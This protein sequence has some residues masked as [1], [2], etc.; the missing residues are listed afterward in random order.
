[1]PTAD[2]EVS[3]SLS[4]LPI[5]KTGNITLTVLAY[6][7]DIAYGR[8]Q[9]FTYDTSL[10]N[11]QYYLTSMFNR[12]TNTSFSIT[13]SA[14][15]MI[16]LSSPF[17]TASDLPSDY[18]GASCKQDY[19]IFMPIGSELKKCGTTTSLPEERMTTDDFATRFYTSP[20]NVVDSC[21]DISRIT[22]YDDITDLAGRAIKV[23]PFG[24]T[25]ISLINKHQSG[26]LTYEGQ[27][28][29]YRQ[30]S[31]VQADGITAFGH[32]IHYLPATNEWISGSTQFF[33]LAKNCYLEFYIKADKIDLNYVKIDQTPLTNLTYTTKDI[34]LF[35]NNIKQFTTPIT[36]YGVHTFANDAGISVSY[37]V[38]K[39]VNGPYNAAGYLT[40]FNKVQN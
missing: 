24:S 38:C 9:I 5:S 16:T 14:P 26:F 34:V 23:S 37:V 29:T 2:T 21:K 20:P 13:S 40:G 15:I 18:C 8:D 35:A 3:G 39:S 19:V 32:F 30:G 10:G 27:M 11:P 4:F 25:A 31:I 33:T 6:E 28:S 1:M 17:V 22:I 12:F 36:G 7:D